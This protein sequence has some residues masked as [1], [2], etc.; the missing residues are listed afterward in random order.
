MAFYGRIWKSRAGATFGTHML[1][2]F[3]ILTNSHCGLLN[4]FLKDLCSLGY[5][6]LLWGLPYLQPLPQALPTVNLYAKYV[7][8]SELHRGTAKP[9]A[10]GNTLPPG[11]YLQSMKY[12]A[13][14]KLIPEQNPSAQSCCVFV[15]S[16]C[17][18]CCC[19]PALWLAE[20]AN[21]AMHICLLH[22][23]SVFQPLLPAWFQRKRNLSAQWQH[24]P[25]LWTLCHLQAA[26]SPRA[27]WTQNQ[28]LCN[29]SY[30]C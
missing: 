16:G 28:M 24:T 23:G 1:K 22:Q 20:H 19:H 26:S 12:T 21:P 6:I 8:F 13:T 14:G 18:L 27:W 29:A 30:H 17:L 25:Q 2:S 5:R 7:L 3:Q 15:C 11:R 4:M 10:R 9:T